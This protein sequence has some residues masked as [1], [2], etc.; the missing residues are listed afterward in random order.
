MFYASDAELVI[1]RIKSQSKRD[2]LQEYWKKSQA[3]GGGESK[4]GV[5]PRDRDRLPLSF[6]E[7]NLIGA[8][9]NRFEDDLRNREDYIDQKFNFIYDHQESKVSISEQDLIIRFKQTAMFESLPKD[10][11][12]HI[13]VSQNKKDLIHKIQFSRLKSSLKIRIINTINRYFSQQRPTETIYT[14]RPETCFAYSYFDNHLVICNLAGKHAQER[15]SQLEQF[16]SWLNLPFDELY[17]L[18][19]KDFLSTK[20]VVI[21]DIKNQEKVDGQ[22]FL[23]QDSKVPIWLQIAHLDLTRE[24][25]QFKYQELINIV[26][27]ISKDLINNPGFDHSQKDI[28]NKMFTIIKRCLDSHGGM[29]KIFQ[30]RSEDSSFKNKLNA[31]S[32]QVFWVPGENVHECPRAVRRILDPLLKGLTSDD[33]IRLAFLCGRLSQ[34]GVLGYHTDQ[35]Q[36]NILF[37][38][39]CEYVYQSLPADK[40]SSAIKDDLL[41]G[42]CI[43]IVSNS[44]K[45]YHQDANPDSV[46]DK[47]KL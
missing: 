3:L 16:N 25:S 6:T 32:Q 35:N 47:K 24:V 46:F 13:D 27:K 21:C 12:D 8:D 43:Q 22:N 1:E 38:T 33:R 30:N 39:I 23:T 40:Q 34:K 28:L 4:H 5:Q 45:R 41:K 36:A 20:N 42:T 9:K 29:V 2:L 31:L 17:Q 7:S 14:V 37:R 15:S 11:K 19:Y 44:F 10:I 18:F 26:L